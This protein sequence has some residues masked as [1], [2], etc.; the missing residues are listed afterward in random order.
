RRVPR[1]GCGRWRVAR[2]RPRRRDGARWRRSRRLCE[3]RRGGH[4]CGS[5]RRT[6]ASRWRTAWRKPL[7][8]WRRRGR[9]WLHQWLRS[10]AGFECGVSCRVLALLCVQLG[11][12]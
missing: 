12:H 11:P 6:V 10:G 7:P 4:R 8:T 9:S 2:S 5:S 1:R 3:S